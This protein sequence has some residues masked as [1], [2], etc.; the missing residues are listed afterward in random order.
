MEFSQIINRNAIDLKY[1][2]KD[3]DDVLRHMVEML[4]KDGAITSVREFLDDVYLRESEG[5]TGIGDN[6][7]IPHGK[8]KCVIKNCVAVCKLVEP[9]EWE[10]I[11][12]QPVNLIILFAVT[13]EGATNT[14][15]KMMA[16]VASA[17]AKEKVCKGIKSATTPDDL[18]AAF[19]VIA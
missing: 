1:R 5:I 10:T 4:Y 2:A 19:S 13:K 17:L 15:L 9:I 8:S 11:D 3:K 7:A 14:H 6:I 18:I 16:C 12:D